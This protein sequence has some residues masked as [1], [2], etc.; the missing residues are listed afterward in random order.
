MDRTLGFAGTSFDLCDI[1]VTACRSPRLIVV[2]PVVALA[3]IGCTVL[4]APAKADMATAQTAITAGNFAAAEAALRPLAEAGDAQ[5]QFQWAKLSLEG[6][7][8]GLPPARAI[9]L[10]IQS[11][12][13]GNAHAQALLGQAYAQGDHVAV[14]NLA[15]Y[16]WLSRASASPDLSN[17][18]R[19][20]VATL[21]AGLL[22]QL[23]PRQTAYKADASA[24]NLADSDKKTVIP[25][26]EKAKAAPVNSVSSVP[27]FENTPLPTSPDAVATDLSNG[28]TKADTKTQVAASDQI[29]SKSAKANTAQS[30]AAVPQKRIYMLQLASLPTSTAATQEAD[31]LRK[32]YAALLRDAEVSIRQVDL[33]KKG[34]MQ[35]VLAGPF[36]SRAIANDRCAQISRQ[37][38]ACRVIAATN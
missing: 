20:S 24:D 16:H 27:F 34:V 1:N 2:A 25:T 10:L 35:R 14:D 17:E 19:S 12:A 11:A 9:S 18:E 13:Q 29:E 6:H 23:A 38:Q 15:A 4:I 3:L 32:K 36:E 8:S 21:R 26:P 37:K 31:R 5:A 30:T 22:E 7:A 33:G 28:E